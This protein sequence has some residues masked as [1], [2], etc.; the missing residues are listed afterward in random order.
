M[1][2]QKFDSEPQDRRR[3]FRNYI[4]PLILMPIVLFLFNWLLFRNHAP[5][6]EQPVVEQ[7]PQQDVVQAVVPTSVPQRGFDGTI[8]EGGR[9]LVVGGDGFGDGSW[10]FITGDWRFENDQL[11][12]AQLDG[13]DHVASYEEPFREYVLSTQLRHNQGIGGGLVFNMQSQDTFA[14]SHMVRFKEDN[15]VMFWGFFDENNGFNGQGFAEMSIAEGELYKLDVHVKNAT[16]DIYLNDSLVLA[17]NPLIYDQ[18]YVGVTS[19]VSEVRF[20]DIQVYPIG[21]DAV[22][23]APRGNDL[24]ENVEA[25]S[26]DW[27]FDGGQITQTNTD[28]FDFLTGLNLFAQNYSLSTVID[29]TEAN[30]DQ[31]I[32]GGFIFHMPDRNSKS[33]A[34]LI[35]FVDGGRSILWGRYDENEN[36]SGEGALEVPY[37]ESGVQELRI[38]VIGDKYD[39]FVNGD[40]IVGDISLNSNEGWIG[41]VSFSGPVTFTDVNLSLEGAN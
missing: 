8:L 41:L 27:V 17:D 12:Q 24:L 39:I 31:D 4:L 23:I 21:G 25:I 20:E 40:L 26:G 5:P 35:R 1:T 28:G 33:N 22:G 29:F 15:T 9:R 30:T 18:G 7:Q 32:G 38:N 16:Y 36:F 3:Y 34:Q 13:F 14:R 2:I 19:S 37:D 6:G 11:I 10:K